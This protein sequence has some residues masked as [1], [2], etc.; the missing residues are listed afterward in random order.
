ML[1]APIRLA[2]SAMIPWGIFN[3]TPLPA[4]LSDI[5]AKEH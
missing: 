2:C 3:P 5:L 1:L 4:C